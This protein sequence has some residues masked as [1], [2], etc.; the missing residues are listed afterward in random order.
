MSENKRQKTHSLDT[1]LTGSLSTQ[2]TTKGGKP[3]TYQITL[4]LAAL[5][6]FTKELK[7]ELVMLRLE[8]LQ[9]HD[10]DIDRSFFMKH[11]ECSI[12][13]LDQGEHNCETK[14]TR[15]CEPISGNP[16]PK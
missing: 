8:H 4:C 10:I 2:E 13:D 15:E 6:F 14:L 12:F 3:P 16:Y 1:S 7:A 11:K 5:I 9:R